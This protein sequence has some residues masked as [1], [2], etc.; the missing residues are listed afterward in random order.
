MPHEK[1]FCE[2]NP[3]TLCSCYFLW[4]VGQKNIFLADSLPQN[5]SCFG[6]K[7]SPLYSIR[8]KTNS[9]QL[10]LCSFRRSRLV[11]K[12]VKAIT[13]SPGRLTDSV[14]N[15]ITNRARR[16][17][18]LLSFRKSTTKWILPSPQKKWRFEKFCSARIRNCYYRLRRQRRDPKVHPKE[19]FQEREKK[20]RAAVVEEVQMRAGVQEDTMVL[21]TCCMLDYKSFQCRPR[22]MSREMTNTV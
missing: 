11:S 4:L 2:N 21:N 16:S 13:L 8:W 19:I 3:K 14:Q 7:S 9:W 5:I 15:K 6:P 22:K 12:Q 1:P 17:V 10:S 18:S 20:I